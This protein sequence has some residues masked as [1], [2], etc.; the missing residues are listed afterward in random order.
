MLILITAD[1]RDFLNKTHS[2]KIDIYIKRTIYVSYFCCFRCQKKNWEVHSILP[3]ASVVVNFFDKEELVTL[4][5]TVHSVI[6]RTPAHLL[7]EVI[8]V[9]DNCLKGML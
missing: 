8:L 9:A 7:E 3:K 6:Q 4:L 2:L 5:R 1:V